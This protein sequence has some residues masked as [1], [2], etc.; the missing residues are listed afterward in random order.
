MKRWRCSGVLVLSSGTTGLKRSEKN[1]HTQA[2]GV[3][4]GGGVDFQ[5]AY[6]S[7]FFPKVYPLNLSVILSDIAAKSNSF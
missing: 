1:I 5:I 6:T 4:W 3:G 7:K 2:G